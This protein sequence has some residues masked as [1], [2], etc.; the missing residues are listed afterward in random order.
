M[1]HNICLW[2]RKLAVL[3]G[4][5]GLAC[6]APEAD[7]FDH[8][9]QVDN[10]TELKMPTNSYSGYLKVNDDKQLHYIFME[11]KHN[12]S[13]DPILVW[14]NGGPGCSSL[15]GFMQEHGPWTI[16]DDAVN[17]TENPYPWIS[18]ASMIYLE[19][20]AG[21]GFSPW[22]IEDKYMIYN[23]LV[24]SEDAYTALKEWYGKF[25]EYGPSGT[26]NPLFISGESYG[27]I[28]SPYL[29]W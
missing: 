10:T 26:N 27:G 21:V 28:Y 3:L 12:A 7:K 25:P 6:G 22:K 29:A 19:S 11:S 18:N 16:E 14:F 4:V 9:L 8:L 13:S 20:P 17:V 1:K 5:I 23:D 2:Q 15:L 24:Q